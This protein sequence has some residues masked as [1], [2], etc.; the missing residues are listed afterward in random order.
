MA[1]LPDNNPFRSDSP[2]FGLPQ[3][4]ESASLPA[5]IERAKAAIVRLM[6]AIPYPMTLTQIVG[7]LTE[8]DPEIRAIRVRRILEANDPVEQPPGGRRSDE[9]QH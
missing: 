3:P 1:L 5:E 4:M 2:D 6:R 8:E 9:P 7:I